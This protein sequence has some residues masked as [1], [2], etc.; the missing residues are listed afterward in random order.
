MVARREFLSGSALGLVALPAL[1]ALTEA[2][3]APVE[4]GGDKSAV[5]TNKLFVQ[6][7]YESRQRNCLPVTLPGEP[8]R[9]F[10]RHVGAYAM[11]QMFDPPGG[12]TDAKAMTEAVGAWH[13]Q[14]TAPPIHSFGPFVAEGNSVVEEWEV[15]MHGLDGTIYNNYYCWIRDFKDG[16]VAQIREYVDSHH[17]AG[18]LSLQAPWKT[19][20]PSTAPRRRLTGWSKEQAAAAAPL[21]E[22]ETVFPIRQEFNLDPKLLRDVIA[23]GTSSPDIADTAASSKAVV[24]AMRDAQAKGDMAAVNAIHGKGYRLFIA[25][26]GPLGWEHIPVEDL[27]APLVKHLKGPIKVRF[28][29][30]VAEGGTVFE[31]MDILAHFDDGTVYNNWHCFMHEVRG[32]KIVQTREYM[33]THHLWVMLG[34]WADWGKT[35]IAPIRRVRRSNLPYIRATYQWT[36]P[37]LKLP[38][39]DPLP[40]PKA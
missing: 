1:A 24:R 33:D 10:E 18:I 36:N 40:P 28:G 12:A 6:H 7:E 35:P 5:E 25:G 8:P 14:S 39:W 37:F 27:Y 22:M 2:Q 19:I 34:R 15:Y 32:G 4:S 29:P 20:E 13:R 16:D 30:M 26:D 21:T 3:A 38:R 31:E 23:T 11:Y 9:T 17:V